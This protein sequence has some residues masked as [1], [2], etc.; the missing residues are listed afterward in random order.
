MLQ[1]IGQD[2]SMTEQQLR[3]HNVQTKKAVQLKRILPEYQLAH[4]RNVY[5][6]VAVMSHTKQ[7]I[8]NINMTSLQELRGVQKPDAHMEDILAAVIMIRNIC[9]VFIL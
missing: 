8:K 4:E 2:M 5:K 9:F 3:V 1:Q 6:T 7:L